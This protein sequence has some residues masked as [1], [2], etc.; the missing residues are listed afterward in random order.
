LRCCCDGWKAGCYYG[1]SSVFTQVC[2][3][4]SCSHDQY[5]EGFKDCN[6]DVFLDVLDMFVGGE[7]R[8][9]CL[10]QDQ[11]TLSLI[12]VSSEPFV[13][14]KIT[15]AV[16]IAFTNLSCLDKL[17]SFCRIEVLQAYFWKSF[18]KYEASLF[19]QFQDVW[20]ET[21]MSILI[22]PIK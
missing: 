3:G 20:P 10:M 11:V 16:Q 17:Q 12:S 1:R 13:V 4:E 19:Q 14:G 5:A 21:N 9:A 22:G 18:Y 8:Q 15:E 6:F 7:E 2:A